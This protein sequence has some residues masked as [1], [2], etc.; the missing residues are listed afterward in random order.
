MDKIRY[1]SYNNYLK[2]KYGRKIYKIALNIGCTCPNRDGTIGRNGCIFCSAGGSGEFA[3]NPLATVTEQINEGRRLIDSKLPESNFSEPSYIAYFQAYT[4]TYGSYDKLKAAYLEA[5]NHPL[6]VSLSIA[7]RPDCIGDDILSL[8]CEINKIKPVTVELGLQTIHENTAV[9]IRR[10]YS[11]PIYTEC[12][13]R[14]HQN[15][16]SVVTH[17]ILGLPGET[18]KD[19]LESVKFVV[20]N[21]TDGIKLQ[22]LHVLKGT[23]LAE[24]YEK[25]DFNTYTLEEYM[26]VLTECVKLIPKNVVIHRLTGDGDKKLLIAPLWSANKKLVINTINKYMMPY[27]MM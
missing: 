22:L 23:E 12:L 20:D 26:D 16:I 21:G 27:D 8:L 9:L 18:K 7:T 19:I 17:L 11:L 14:L 2:E 4:N 6:V 5:V 3:G 25:G 15:G 13:E 1:T 10:G 24:M